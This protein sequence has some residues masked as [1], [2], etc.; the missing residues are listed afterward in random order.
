MT[1]PQWRFESF[2]LD[3]VNACLWWDAEAVVLP[4]QNV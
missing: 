3:P 1:A 2:R 4:P